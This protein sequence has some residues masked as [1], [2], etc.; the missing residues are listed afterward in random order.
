MLNEKRVLHMTKMAM[1]EDEQSR[2]LRPA[3]RYHKKDY[4][5]LCTIGGFFVGS[6]LYAALYVGVLMVLA[7][8]VFVNISLILII[9]VILLGILLY[10]VFLYFYLG[11][12][13]AHAKKQYEKGHKIVKVLRKDYMEL[14]QMYVE[15]EESRIPGGMDSL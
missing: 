3:I 14:Q 1:L 8:T 9:L 5:S 4:V 2:L 11:A 15:E 13:R 12:V 7:S 6:I 10:A